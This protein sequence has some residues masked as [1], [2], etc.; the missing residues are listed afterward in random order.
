MK[1]VKVDLSNEIDRFSKT[2]FQEFFKI[3]THCK[4]QIFKFTA[5]INSSTT[6]YSSGNFPLYSF[7]PQDVLKISQKFNEAVCL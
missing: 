2:L 3:S 7:Y 4:V 1:L 5:K 6:K